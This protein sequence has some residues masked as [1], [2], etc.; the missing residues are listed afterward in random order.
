MPAAEFIAGWISGALGLVVGHPIDTVKVR[1]QT[2]SKYHGILD[3]VIKTYRK[4][5]ILGFFKGM[6]FPVGSVAISNSL[7][8]GSYSN[9]LLYLSDTEY[10]DWTNPPQNLHVYMSGCFSGLVQIYVSAPIDLIK[11][12]LQNQTEPFGVKTR[13]GYLHTRYRG[14]FHCAICIFRE[15]GI[16]GLYRGSIALALR[17]VPT[18]GLYFLTYEVVCKWMTKDK[19]VPGAWTMLFAGGCAGTVGWAFA[20][21]MDV[22]KARLQMDG[23]QRVQ[24]RGIL[25]CIIKSIRQEGARVLLKGLTINSL[26]AFPVNAV[27]FL[28]YEMLLKVFR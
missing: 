2:Q 16:V 9:A 13:P 26:R 1:L 3:C 17:D 11:V 5:T 18:M 14:P 19:E 8:F 10:K 24:Y 4:E 7:A 21:P 12:R 15:E 6:S 28:S 20:N 23:M 27:T 25:D 22:I